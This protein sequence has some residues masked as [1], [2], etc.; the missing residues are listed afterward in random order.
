MARLVN[1]GFHVVVTT[2]SPFFVEQLSNCTVAGTKHDEGGPVPDQEKL[3][4]N[5]IAAYGFVPDDGGYKITPLDVDDEGI[6]QYEFTKVY[7]RLYNELLEL[8]AD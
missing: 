7:D 6:P 4:K 5:N 2:H 8:E 1:N 3:D